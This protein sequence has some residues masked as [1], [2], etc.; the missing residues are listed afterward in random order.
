M[1]AAFWYVE[2]HGIATE[3]KY[4]Y[5]GKTQKCTYNSSQQ[6][7]RNHECAEVPA[8]RTKALESAVY[9]QPVSISVEASFQFYK[10]GVFSG[11]C[12]LV[13]DHGIVLTGYGN[14]NGKDYWKAKNSWG[15]TW[16]M[17]GYILIAKSNQDGPG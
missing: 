7:F 8:N 10:S 2:D 3:E 1:N 14:L 12:G 17:Q 15:A 9:K 4:R 13:L 11:K 6:V 16:G 5:T